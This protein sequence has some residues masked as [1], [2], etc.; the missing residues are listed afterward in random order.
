MCQVSD[1]GE[2]PFLPTPTTISVAVQQGN[3][4]AIL[5]TSSHMGEDP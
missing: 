5:G 2:S 4:A 1:E 3:A